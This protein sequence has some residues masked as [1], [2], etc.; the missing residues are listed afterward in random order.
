MS[1]IVENSR[2]IICLHSVPDAK[3]STV[4]ER[5]KWEE[6]RQKDTAQSGLEGKNETVDRKQGKATTI[7]DRLKKKVPHRRTRSTKLMDRILL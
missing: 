1:V 2:E 7:Q 6:V 3:D 5:T 4:Q